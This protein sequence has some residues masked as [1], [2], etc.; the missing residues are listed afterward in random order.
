MDDHLH[1]TTE[2]AA[3][4]DVARPLGTAIA[5]LATC[6]LVGLLVGTIVGV[7]RGSIAVDV[8]TGVTFGTAI[9]GLLAIVPVLRMFRTMP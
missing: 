4:V 1:P 3:A 9:G 7:V 8:V 6:A 2:A 5:V